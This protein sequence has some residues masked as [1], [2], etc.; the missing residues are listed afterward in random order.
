[1]NK[2]EYEVIIYFKDF[3]NDNTDSPSV[4]ITDCSKKIAHKC[5]RSI[6]RQM[7]YSNAVKIPHYS[8]CIPTTSIAYACIRIK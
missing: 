1:M 3:K 8:L 2:K 4:S 6:K 5:F 7:K